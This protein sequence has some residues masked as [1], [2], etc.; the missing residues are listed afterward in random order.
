[1]V[2][3][4]SADL[5]EV[6]RR[7]GATEYRKTHHP[8]RKLWTVSEDNAIKRLAEIHGTANWTTIALKLDSKYGI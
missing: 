8:K 6:K 4:T 3:D 7:T 5:E 2:T 1:M